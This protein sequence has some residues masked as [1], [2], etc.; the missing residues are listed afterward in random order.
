MAVSVLLN[1][2][3]AE[4]IRKLTRPKAFAPRPRAKHS[5]KRDDLAAHHEVNKWLKISQSFQTIFVLSF[6]H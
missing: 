6:K 1:S 3:P 5:L 4:I 2:K